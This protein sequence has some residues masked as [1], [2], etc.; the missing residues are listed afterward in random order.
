MKP[1]QVQS[2]LTR[3]LSEAISQLRDPRIPMIVTI[4]RVSLTGDFGLAR[5]Y[6]SAMNADMPELI[7]A[8]THARGFLQRQVAEHVRMKRTP[9][10]EFRSAID[11]P[12]SIAEA[13]NQPL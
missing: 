11:N 2:Q 1:I 13:T 7:D 9:T 3:V 5:V 8:L 4:E 10:L 12:I 6:I